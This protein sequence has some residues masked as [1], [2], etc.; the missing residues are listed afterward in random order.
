MIQG[1]AQ[2]VI[3]SKYFVIPVAVLSVLLISVILYLASIQDLIIL[4]V[5][6]QY[7]I[8]D[9][10]DDVNGG[11]SE[12]TEMSN[13]DSVFVFRFQLK[14]GFYSPYAGF[15]VTPAASK[16][17]DAGKYNQI[18]LCLS[19]TNIDRLGIALY[20]P[21]P[22]E[23]NINSEDENLHHSYLSISEKKTNYQ[24]PF[25]QLKHPEWWLDLHQISES[26]IIKPD[27][28]QIIHV[29]IGSAYAPEIEKEK[30]LNVYSISFTRNNKLIFIAL[31]VI[32][33]SVIMLL[34]L[35][36]YWK[37][38]RKTKKAE[39]TIAYKPVEI[40]TGN[41]SNDEICIDYINQSFQ[42]NDLTLDLV[43]KETGILQRK[44]T[45]IIN[46]QFNCNFK[47]YINRIRINE[48]KRLL[49]QTDLNI[50]EIAFKVGFNNQS[51]FNRVFKVETQMS[52]SEYRDSQA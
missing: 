31:A 13:S 7:I 48:A 11:R 52:P 34:Y 10:T 22:D 43:A 9:Y 19:G 14:E 12:I 30:T 37:M 20:T 44:I 18:N 42:N 39:I 33:L 1:K 5:S 8:E 16:L 50:G 26:E 23:Y 17:I 27:F 49:S 15:R 24:I 32:Y 28:S 46:E 6:D 29:N 41:Q 25:N 35:F 3:T 47:T 51:H 36:N 21:I 38:F 40:E 45:Q 2:K 4:P